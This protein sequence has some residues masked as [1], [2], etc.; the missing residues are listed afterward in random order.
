M[1]KR[2]FVSIITVLLHLVSFSQSQN[3]LVNIGGKIFHNPKSETN[4]ILGTPYVQSKF[5]Y[6]EIEDIP[7]KHFMRYNAYSDNF[8]FITFQNDTLEMEKINDIN[9]I[10]FTNPNKK[11]IYLN[12]ISAAKGRTKGFLV[13]IHAKGS[14]ILYTK[15]SVTFYA[16][17]KPET[18]KKQI[19]LLVIQ[20]LAIPI[21]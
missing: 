19:C 10:T 5:A 13:E 14:F 21:F 6:A 15:E 8:E 12:Y 17:K 3:L 11:Y 4:R 2:I 1:R 20:K 16:G 9:T 7:Q 18:H